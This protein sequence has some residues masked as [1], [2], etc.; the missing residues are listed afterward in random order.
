MV[1]EPGGHK[2][3]PPSDR[4]YVPNQDIWMKVDPKTMIAPPRSSSSSCR[5]QVR[6]TLFPLVAGAR[7]FLTS[8]DV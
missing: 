3:Q 5:D 2:L 4:K 1:V 8:P 6:E 7:A